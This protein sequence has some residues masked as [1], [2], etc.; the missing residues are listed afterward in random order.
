MVPNSSRAREVYKSEKL[1]WS[2]FVECERPL[3]LNDQMAQW[4]DLHKMSSVAMKDVIVRLW[5]AEAIPGSYFGLAQRLVDALPRIDAVKRWSFM[6]GACMV[7][8]VL[9][10]TW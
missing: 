4:A 7:S 2:Q 6:E 3:L 5:P 10:C 1:F 9:R 8:P